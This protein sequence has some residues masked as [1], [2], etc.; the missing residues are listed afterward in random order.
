MKFSTVIVISSFLIVAACSSKTPPVDEKVSTSNPNQAE[1]NVEE[2]YG[3]SE[4]MRKQICKEIEQFW[5][6]ALGQ[7][8][9][10]YPYNVIADLTADENARHRIEEQ[11]RKR[12]ELL[13]SIMDKYA[14]ELTKKYDLSPEQLADI[15]EEGI[16]KGWRQYP[17][18]RTPIFK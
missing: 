8:Y 4:A 14:S 15:N 12:E 2:K 5:L 7:V 11:R 16:E 18:P 3:L 9:K 17:P 1:S 13:R 6:Q 10:K